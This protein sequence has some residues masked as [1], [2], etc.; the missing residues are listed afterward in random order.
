MGAGRGETRRVQSTA[1]VYEAE[2]G[3]IDFGDGNGPVPAHRHPNGL[4]WVADTAEVAI[5]AH[6]GPDAMV[7]GEARVFESA[8]VEGRARVYERAKVYGSAIVKDEG[9]VYGEAEICGRARVMNN[10]HAR[11]TAHIEMN[12]V[13]ANQVVSGE[14][15]GS[16]RV[17]GIRTA[18]DGTV[19]IDGFP[20][21]EG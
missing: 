4:G 6:V 8:R 15:A 1:F 12:W 3:E 16:V 20:E 17:T 19:L 7:Y 13:N 2:T 18:G 14:A 21:L 5:T 10:A 9:R 11:G